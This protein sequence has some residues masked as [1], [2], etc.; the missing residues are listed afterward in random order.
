MLRHSGRMAFFGAAASWAIL[1]LTLAMGG[2]GS[3]ASL[4][5]TLQGLATGAIVCA[6]VA[7]LLAIVALVRGPQRGSAAV[8][9]VLGVLYL[10]AFSGAGFGL[11]K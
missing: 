1:A 2:L 7:S 8:G 9:L 3:A 10:L 11:L 5:R 4:A 6:V